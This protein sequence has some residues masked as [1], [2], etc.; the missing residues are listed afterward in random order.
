MFDVSFS[1]PADLTARLTSD[2]D[3]TVDKASR[4]LARAYT[5]GLEVKSDTVEKPDI[6][7][8]HRESDDKRMERDDSHVKLYDQWGNEI[9]FDVYH[10]IAS[11]TR[12]K[13]LEKGLYPV[14]SSCVGKNDHVL[15]V[16][17]SGSGKTTTALDLV[18]R[19]NMTMVSG[20]KTLVS[21]D[22]GAMK[23]VAGTPTI[24]IR[25][26]DRDRYASVIGESV[27]YFD[28]LA[29]ELQEQQY[30]APFGGNI[31]AIAVIRLHDGLNDFK[32]YS[33]GS[34]LHTL[35]PYL[36]DT[37]NANTIVCDGHGI[38]VGNP[39]EGTP[40]RL[41]KELRE[42]LGKIPV[43]SIAG[44]LSFVADKIAKL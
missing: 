12:V 17:H 22:S 23:V 9:K 38:F 4:M 27:S 6:R 16:G 18:Q 26:S 41:T 34:A 30:T 43:Y 5:P 28:R 37:V 21:M 32:Q 19:H 2:R 24:T 29:F 44:P 15:I 14:H 7:I 13:L 42:A 20:N 3:L 33:P 11:A 25:Q 35:H 36:L 40:E 10:L 8:D 1:L 31:R 39:P